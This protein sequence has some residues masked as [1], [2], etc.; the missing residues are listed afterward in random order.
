M[1]VQP[2]TIL[3]CRMCSTYPLSRLPLASLPKVA[4]PNHRSACLQA[5]VLLC[6]QSRS[7]GA[8]DNG[9]E[10]RIEEAH[11][12]RPELDSTPRIIKRP[13]FLL[14]LLMALLTSGTAAGSWVRTALRRI[15][16]PSVGTYSTSRDGQLARERLLCMAHP[17]RGRSLLRARRRLCG[18]NAPTWRHRSSRCRRRRW[19]RRVEPA[20]QSWLHALHAIPVP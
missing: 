18:T 3:P 11:V 9:V 13:T 8:A 12:I 7:R 2:V 15:G 1:S 14:R 6:G 16:I 10:S 5:C 4:C 17:A 19:S 20:L